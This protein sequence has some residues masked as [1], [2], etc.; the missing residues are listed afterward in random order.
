MQ[1]QTN[2]KIVGSALIGFAL[3]GGAYLISDFNKKNLTIETPVLQTSTPQRIAIAV[4]DSD[5]NGIEDWRDEFV[6]SE[7]IILDESSTTYSLPDTLTGR[8]GISLMENIIEAKMNGP[9]GKP[10]EALIDNAVNTLAAETEITLYD[11]L[12]ISI[13]S[14]WDDEDIRNYANTVAAVIYNNSVEMD[15]ELEVIYDIIENDKPERVSE[16][17]I[18]ANVY[19]N[20]RDDTLKI[21][22]PAFL[23]KEHLDLINTYHA[24]H[25]DIRALSVIFTDPAVSLLRLKR[26]QDDATGLGL[27][28]QNMYLALEP[29][30]SLVTADDPATLFILFSPDLKS[31]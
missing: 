3:I 8:V 16:L 25:E 6:T 11:T 22:V 17:E 28:F 20:Y 14:E 24:I 9:F 29:Y 18:I 15:G 1:G 2:P 4:T 26:Y 21:P 27:A 7:P 30:A 13:M 10:K 5:N 23:A 12:D 19:K 31:N